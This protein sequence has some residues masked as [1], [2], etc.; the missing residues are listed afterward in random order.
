MGAVDFL[1]KPV[2]DAVLLGGVASASQ[3]STERWREREEYARL[4]D[5]DARLTP[6]EREVCALVARGLLNKQIAFDLGTSEKTIKVHR[7]R[8]MA[9][10]GVESVAELVR[11][12]DR[13]H[14][15]KA[16]D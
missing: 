13:L 4:R 12:V 6:R 1:T 8:V 10:L 7:A 3:R 9:K 15:G 14:V 16:T 11:F 5:R 2:D